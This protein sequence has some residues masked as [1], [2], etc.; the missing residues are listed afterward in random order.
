MHKIL[1]R[2]DYEKSSD[3]VAPFLIGKVLV[4]SLGKRKLKGV[5]VETEAYGGQNDP[6]SHAFKGKTKRNEVM[7]GKAGYAYVYFTYGFHHCLNV[8]TGK[9][10]KAEA[11]LIRALEPIERIDRMARSRGDVSKGNL[12][13]G[14]GKICQAFAI[15]SRQNGLDL[16][17]R[18]SELYIED[19]GIS[20]SV[21]TSARIGIT[22][23][24]EKKWRFFD[25]SSEFVSHR[26]K[27]NLPQEK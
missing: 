14:P 5:I 19:W 26:S 6:A 23:A 27:L 17:K 21:Q 20:K 15:N 22:R 1:E 16:T 2:K 18:S 13:N 11:V 7:F 3:L 8:V 12:T 25:P 9:E 10:G 24:V 4:K